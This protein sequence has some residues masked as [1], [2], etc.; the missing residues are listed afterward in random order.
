MMFKKTRQKISNDLVSLACLEM[1]HEDRIHA[2]KDIK[3][4][5]YRH[6]QAVEGFPLTPGEHKQLVNMRANAIRIDKKN[7][8][9]KKRICHELKAKHPFIWFLFFR[10]S[11]I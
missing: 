2:L 1:D 9:R 4:S 5:S 10:G 7:I 3:T 6:R 8:A 11:K